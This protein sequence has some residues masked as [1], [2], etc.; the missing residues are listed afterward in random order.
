MSFLSPWALWWLISLPLLVTFY[1]FRPEPLRRLSSAFFLWK[2]SVPESQ[3]GVFAQR[4][5]SNPLLWLQLLVLLLLSLYLARPATSWKSVLPTNSKI[6]LVVDC[7]ASMRTD[8]AFTEAKEKVGQALD[9]LFG[10]TNFG[11]HPEVML[12]AV[13]REPR[14]LVPFTRDSA[15]LRSALAA[16][17]ASEIPDRLESLR[18]FLANLITEKKASIWLFGDHLPTDLELPG[19]QFSRCGSRPLSNVGVTAFS[20]EVSRE[21]GSPKPMVYLRAQ[22]FS[23]NAEQRLLRVESL[24]LT[25]PEQAQSVIFEQL[26]TLPAQGGRTISQPFLA[27]RLSATEATLFRATLLPT[28]GG[29]RDQFPVDDT[30]YATAP[31]FGA[32]RTT[33][34]FSPDLKGGFLLR[35]LMAYPGVEVLDWKAFQAQTGQRP[36]DLLVSS[37]NFPLPSSVPVR[38]RIL[39]TEEAPKAGTPVETLQPESH[40][41][42]VSNAGVEWERLR[43]QRASD[44]PR[45]NDEQVLLRTASGPALTL[46]G[47]AAGRPTLSWRFPLSHSSLPLSPALPILTSRFLRTYAQ[48]PTQVLPRSLS[49]Q[50]RLNRPS[51][52]N[53]SGPLEFTGVAGSSRKDATVLKLDSNENQLPRFPVSGLYQV[54]NRDGE[55]AWIAVNLFSP[56]ESALPWSDADQTFPTESTPDSPEASQDQ[57]QFRLVNAPLAAIALLLLFLEAYLL[58][59]RGRP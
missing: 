43:V 14:I 10:V 18:P 27:T 25:R 37:P 1:L 58:L 13:D 56:T 34:A 16:L 4:L 54:R 49:T 15:Q 39:I 11:S 24:Q 22:S 9:G 2:K 20:I 44:W 36:L 23:D 33:V 51:G 53:W 5:R 8:N 21:S 19:L 42:M 6:V 47:L 17:S 35:A 29:S 7:S 52:R 59:R 46:S 12:I 26:V 57:Q 45:F 31:P 28:P 40:Q 30:A 41:E 3:G 32:D 55:S 38:T 50:E 48:P